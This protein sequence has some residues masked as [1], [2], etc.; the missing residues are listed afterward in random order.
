MIVA[1]TA[2]LAAQGGM[3]GFSVGCIVSGPALEFIVIHVIMIGLQVMIGAFNI[4]MLLDEIDWP[5]W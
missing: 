5:G 2:L 4:V 1:L 3:I